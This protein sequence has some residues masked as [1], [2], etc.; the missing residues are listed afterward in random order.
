M[1]TEFEKLLGAIES[2]QE[3]AEVLH[4]SMPGEGEADDEKIAA[5]AE[6]GNPDADGDG[7]NDV[8]GEATD[9]DADDEGEGE[10]GE[11]MGKSFSFTL[12]DG[13]VV[14]AQDGTELVKSL[15]ARVEGTE[16]VMSKALGAAVDL[17]GKQGD[18]I[19]SLQ[20]QITAL[21]STGRGRKAVLSVAE[22]PAAGDLK[23]SLG[24]EEEKGMSVNEFMA[25][26]L[27]A[28][29][30]GK[31][32]GLDIARAESALNKGLPVPQDIVARVTQ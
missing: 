25:K 28:Q 26:A 7:Q 23:K 2:M 3:D 13:T 31:I 11:S 4:K 30:A 16:E 10:E 20:E 9:G 22:K 1:A 15:I 27:S 32:T 21:G 14:E 17:I 19:K 5:A 6:D 8:S 24:Q 18:M 12:E 29:T